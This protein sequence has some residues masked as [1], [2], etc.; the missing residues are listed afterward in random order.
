M[1]RSNQS[2]V[3]KDWI[4]SGARGLELDP[5][6]HQHETFGRLMDVV[7]V[8]DVV[9]GPQDLFETFYSRARK[10]A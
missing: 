2:Q 1:D 9:K 4:R 5:F 8:G 7:P 3:D 10:F 6:L